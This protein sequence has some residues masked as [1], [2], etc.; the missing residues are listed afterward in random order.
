[1]KVEGLLL[2]IFAHWHL[3]VMSDML[4]GQFKYSEG[5]LSH[6]VSLIFNFIYVL[7]QV[8]CNIPNTATL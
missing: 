1:M 3:F 7:R 2:S 5:L 8:V 6:N 4:V